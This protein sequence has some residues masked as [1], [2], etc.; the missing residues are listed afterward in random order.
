MLFGPTAYR[1]I[2]L[3]QNQCQTFNNML[4]VVYTPENSG[5]PATS[6]SKTKKPP[7]FTEGLCRGGRKLSV[8]FNKLYISD[9][10]CKTKNDSPNRSLNAKRTISKQIVL[11]LC[12]RKGTISIKT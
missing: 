7:V 10:H 2:L 6:I 1:L 9:L 3:I 5:E 8:T 12:Y 11:P 4:F